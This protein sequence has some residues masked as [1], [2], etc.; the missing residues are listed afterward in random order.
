MTRIC[1]GDGRFAF[2]REMLPLAIRPGGS[3]IDDGRTSRDFL[4]QTP[5]HPKDFAR[6][7]VKRSIDSDD[8]PRRVETQYGGPDREGVAV[9]N[10]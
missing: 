6:Q 3:R 4:R 7:M 8:V 2:R 1:S 9:L 10:G 5:N